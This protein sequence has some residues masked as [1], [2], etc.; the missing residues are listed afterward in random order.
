MQYMVV[1]EKGETSYGAFVPDLPGCIAVGET[2]EEALSLIREAVEFHLEDMQAEGFRI[3][4]P[5]SSSTF[6]DVAMVE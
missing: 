6:I 4:M 3:P 5:A 2:R 1:L